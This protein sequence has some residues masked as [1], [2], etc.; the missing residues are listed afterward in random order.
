MSTVSSDDF[1][2]DGAMPYRFVDV[3]KLG[4]AQKGHT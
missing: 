3:I 1:Y 2:S 4:I